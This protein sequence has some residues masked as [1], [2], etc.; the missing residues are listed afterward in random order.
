MKR[1]IAIALMLAIPYLL[2]TACGSSVSG[3]NVSGTAAVKSET[4]LVSGCHSG[5]LSTVTGIKIADEWAASIHSGMNVAGCVDCHNHAHVNS[6]TGCHGAGAP[7]GNGSAAGNSSCFRCHD[8]ANTMKP[9]DGKHL[10]AEPQKLDLTTGIP[11]PSVTVPT[12]KSV[13]YAVLRGTPY[14]SD[15]RW[16]HN[17][18][19]NNV[20][21]EHREWSESGHGEVSAEAFVHYDFKVYGT[22]NVSPRTAAPTDCVRCHTATGYLNYVNSGFNDVRPWGA[23]RGADGKPLV[24]SGLTVPIS[25][26]KQAIYCNVCHDNGSGSAYGYKMRKVPQVTAYYNY[27]IPAAI[28]ANPRLI[29]NS[30]VFPDVAT[31]NTCVVCHSG[32]ENGKTLQKVFE[33]ITDPAQYNNMGF[34]NS[35]YLAAGGDVFKAIGYEF[36]KQFGRSYNSATDQFKHDQIGVNNTSGTG[37]DGPCVTCHLRPKRHSFLPVVRGEYVENSPLLD[38]DGLVYK[39]PLN[40]SITALESPVCNSVCHIQAP[41][42]AATLGEKKDGYRHAIRVLQTVFE[43]SPNFSGRIPQHIVNPLSNPYFFNMSSNGTKPENYSK[44]S[45]AS[46]NVFKRWGNEGNMGAAF[47]LNLLFRDFGGFAHNDLYA[48]RLIYDSMDWLDGGSEYSVRTTLNSWYAAPPSGFRPAGQGLTSEQVR[49]TMDYLLVGG[50]K[51][52]TG[53]ASSAD[54]Y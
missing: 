25:N 52:G 50:F 14:E 54:R 12:Y 30:F 20:T 33:A 48:K 1:R 46:A 40:Q 31:S 21:E 39:I 10:S 11:L 13:G 42:T 23:K 17:P 7:L 5:T 3:G 18:H 41:W 2:L 49:K 16:C 37:N 22:D 4:C 47:N 9:L 45:T 36:P 32:R 28:P 44:T 15:C 26:Q 29:I 8:G 38:K 51:G 19:N 43:T 6:C 27:N 34:I 35:H 24:V 53:S